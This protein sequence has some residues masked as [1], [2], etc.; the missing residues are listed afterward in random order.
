MSKCKICESNNLI[1]YKNNNITGNIEKMFTITD[2]NYGVTG[3]LFK[4]NEC[5][6][7]QCIDIKNPQI[8]YETVE[9]ISYENSRY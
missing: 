1:L 4:C 8:Y 6:F 5:N 2:F 9:D 7:I 3:K